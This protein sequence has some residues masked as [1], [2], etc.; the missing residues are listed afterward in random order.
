MAT[1]I[2]NL[3]ELFLE[4]LKNGNTLSKVPAKLRKPMLVKVFR[5]EPYV[6]LQD[7][8]NYITGYFSSKAHKKL[9]KEY[10]IPVLDL[11]AKTLKIEKFSLML[12]NATDDD[13]NPVSYLGK[14]VR[15]IIEDFSLSRPLK[16]GV[17]VNKFVV[18][19]MRDEQVK[20]AV[21]QSVHSS[22][23]KSE[24]NISF[25]EYLKNEVKYTAGSVYEKFS[26][27]HYGGNE[28]PSIDLSS[29][30]KTDDRFKLGELVT[31]I[32]DDKYD[33]KATNKGKKKRS[34][35][36]EVKEEAV[37][38]AKEEIK[39]LE[40]AKSE[41]EELPTTV[42]KP[43]KSTRQRKAL[44]PKQTEYKKEEKEEPLTKVKMEP[45]F[46]TEIEKILQ[47][48]K[49]SKS[50]P[51]MDFLDTKEVKT[52]EK[53]LKK[54]S[55]KKTKKLSQFREY[56]E[57]YDQ[58]CKGGKNSVMSKGGSTTLSTPLKMSMRISERLAKT[59]KIR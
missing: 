53:P 10:E 55:P 22:R 38:E 52:E 59:K 23:V 37:E 36:K 26:S 17:D 14:E 6:F 20:L 28:L 42:Q 11:K 7:K 33:P 45:E 39:E 32:V 54:P 25:E 57:W 4:F 8:E 15:F 12:S 13:Y 50:T 27:V 2:A 29:N 40:S 58:K 51:D 1:P 5:T 16:R 44:K 34:V 41:I 49:K 35:K 18:N 46:K 48:S 9:L 19:I 3:K 43:K 56:M 24:E 21:A 31:C 47:Y 30:K